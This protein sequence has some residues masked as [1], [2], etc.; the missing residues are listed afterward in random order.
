MRLQRHSI[1]QEQKEEISNFSSWLLA[2]GDGTI[3]TPD[4]EDPYNTKIIDIPDRHLIRYDEIALHSLISFIYDTE[5]L[6]NPS[7]ESLSRKAIV[8]PTNEKVHEI[9]TL[10][11]HQQISDIKVGFPAGPLEVRIIKKWIPHARPQLLCYLFVDV[12]GNAIKA[13]ADVTDESYFDSVISVGSCY[14]V[15]DTL[16]VAAKTYQPAVSH[17]ASLS[18]GR[19]VVFTPIQNN[20]IPTY[21]FEFASYDQLERHT[22]EQKQLADF[23]GRIEN[24]TPIHDRG[25]KPMRKITLQDDRRNIIEVTFWSGKL[26]EVEGDIPVGEIMAVTG[27]T[28]TKFTVPHTSTEILQLES[29]EATTATINPPIPK[30]EAYKNRYVIKVYHTRHYS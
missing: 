4:V 9:N 12:H 2:I 5:S 28:V 21:H 7:P 22:K 15:T 26:S 19:S 14:R 6:H 11:E 3:G 17:E 18:I 20:N 13:V 25:G 16:T 10:M 29:N 24:V 1:T 8:C 30:I 23:I 27:T